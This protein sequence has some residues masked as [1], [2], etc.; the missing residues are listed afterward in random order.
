MALDRGTTEQVV[1]QALSAS[2]KDRRLTLRLANIV[3]KLAASPAASFPTIF[4]AAELE[5]AYRFF[6]NP[7]V[8]GEIILSGHYASV[9]KLSALQ[10]TLIVHDTTKFVFD[11]EGER[12]GL[13][14]I[15]TG[16]QAFFAHFSLVLSA[17]GK[18]RPLGVAALQTWVRDDDPDA[19][20]E[21]DRWARGVDIASSRLGQTAKRIH[22]MDREADDYAL[23]AHLAK[24]NQSFVIRLMH[25]RILGE[26]FDGKAVKISNILSQVEFIV[27]RSATLSRRKDG[28][29]SPAQ[30]KTHSA[31]AARTAKLAVGA[32]RIE[33]PRRLTSG[34]D[35][36]ERLP[37]NLVRVLEI[38]APEGVEPVEWLLLTDQPIETPEDLDR[39]V[40]TYRARWTIEEL[41]KVI[42][43]GCAFEK[44]QLEEYEGLVNALAATIPIACKALELRTRARI[45]PD[46]TDILLDADHLLVL[47][48]KGR[49]KLPAQPTNREILLAVAALGG[50]IKWNGDPGW[51][52]I[53]GGLEKLLS[54]TEGYRIAKLQLASDQ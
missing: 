5:G 53:C 48:A 44:R 36:P 46:S 20:R 38:D 42:K 26:Q 4:N 51:K 34:D 30:K 9:V 31:R 2:F 32:L 17:D 18:R 11:P 39:I 13:G 12:V 41:F 25:D 24:H 3:E 15:R 7:N 28:G 37:I 35:L 43:T 40:D 21:R 1:Q 49:L 23:F 45:E 52:T 22:V 14:R 10:P 19:P 47:R 27:Q 50:H 54:L 6:G 16:G 29:R 8:T 33:I